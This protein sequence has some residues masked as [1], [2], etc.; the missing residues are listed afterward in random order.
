MLMSSPVNRTADL[1]RI[2][3]HQQR[4]LRCPATSSPSAGWSTRP[5]VTSPADRAAAAGDEGNRP[6]GAPFGFDPGRAGKGACDEA[7]TEDA[8]IGHSVWPGWP[9]RALTFAR[10]PAPVSLVPVLLRAGCA[11]RSPRGHQRPSG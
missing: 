1:E 10:S 9:L 11:L 6:H 8:P 2:F 7:G 5:W 4:P 3:L